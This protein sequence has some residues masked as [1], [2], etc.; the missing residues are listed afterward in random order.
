MASIGVGL[1]GWISL[2]LR[3][4]EIAALP[5]AH[6]AFDI[7]DDDL[8]H[9]EHGAHCGGGDIA[10]GAGHQ[11][12]QPLGRDLPGETIAV[13]EPAAGGFGAALGE[14][15]PQPVDLFLGVA[16]DQERDG[17]VEANV[18]TAVHRKEGLSGELEGYQ[19]DRSLL[20]GIG[21]SVAGNIH[22]AAVVEERRVE[23]RRLLGLVIEPEECPDLLTDRRHAVSP[24]RSWT[25][26][27]LSLARL[28]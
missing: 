5:S 16:F 19:H 2:A 20:A 10:V 18:R 8:L 24:V 23:A 7:I 21:G 14:P 27:A 9:L 11:F 25:A 28:R 4:V 1:A 22:D 15:A 6:G 17:F 26:L 3:R 13:P 12:E